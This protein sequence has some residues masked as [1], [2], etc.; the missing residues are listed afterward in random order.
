MP[1]VRACVYVFM[2]VYVRCC[3]EQPQLATA[4]TT[5]L[6]KFATGPCPQ[7][8]HIVEDSVARARCELLQIVLNRDVVE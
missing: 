6:E 4:T 8:R 3:G 1:Q 2:S 7:R 5:T